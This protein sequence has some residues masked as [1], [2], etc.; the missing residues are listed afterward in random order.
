M[1]GIE[2]LR[3]PIEA[4]RQARLASKNQQ[5]TAREHVTEVMGLLRGSP[6]NRASATARALAEDAA[7]TARFGWE[8]S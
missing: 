7:Q 6:D 3:A 2:L 5:E 4:L 8:G 1:I